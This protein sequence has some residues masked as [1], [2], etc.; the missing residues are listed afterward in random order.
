MKITSIIIDVSIVAIQANGIAEISLGRMDI[1]NTLALSLIK[2][3]H[4]SLT[5]CTLPVSQRV[6]VIERDI[7]GEIADGSLEITKHTMG[8]GSAH[9]ETFPGFIIA[10]HTQLCR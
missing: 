4:L 8:D 1:Q 3:I 6:L 7:I 5:D 9:Q 2:F 10:R